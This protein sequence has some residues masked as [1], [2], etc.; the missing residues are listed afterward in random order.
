M[1]EGVVAR[2]FMRGA[3]YIRLKDLNYSLQVIEEV[4][5]YVG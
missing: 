1:I 4:L 2:H 3:K 5:L